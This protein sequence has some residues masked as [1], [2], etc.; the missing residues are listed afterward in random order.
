MKCKSWAWQSFLQGLPA[1]GAALQVFC[2][3]DMCTCMSSV[4]LTNAC[5]NHRGSQGGN[6]P[7]PKYNL[8]CE[9]RPDELSKLTK[10]FL[11][12]SR[13]RFHTLP[14]NLAFSTPITFLHSNLQPTSSSLRLTRLRLQ[15]C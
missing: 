3:Q 15:L 13:L 14:E 10:Q 6:L 11:S 4:L 1:P 5:S 8:L 9:S 12:F 2:E 7:G